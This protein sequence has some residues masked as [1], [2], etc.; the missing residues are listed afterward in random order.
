MGAAQAAGKMIAMGWRPIN[1]TYFSPPPEAEAWVEDIMAMIAR[2]E[3]RCPRKAHIWRSLFCHAL[4]VDVLDMIAATKA[5]NV[6]PDEIADALIAM[7]NC[8][9]LSYEAT[10]GCSCV[11][12][13][14]CM[15]CKEPKAVQ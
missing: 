12:V 4:H 13:A 5:L 11:L 14:V 3:H 8:G 2:N 15:P 1:V 10:P 7:Q 6:T 9:L